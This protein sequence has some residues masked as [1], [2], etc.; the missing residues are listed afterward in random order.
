MKGAQG[1][2]RA[3]GGQGRDVLVGGAGD[4]V[5]VGGAGN[6]RL[7]GRDADRFRD[8]LSCGPGGKDRAFADPGDVVR[9]SCEIVVQNDAPTDVTL[10][11]SSV[12]ENEPVGTEVGT[13]SASDPDPGDSPAFALVAGSGAEGNGAFQIS[14]NTLETAAILDFEAQSTY[15]IRV[16]ATDESGASFEKVLTVAVTNEPE[17]AGNLAPTN[18]TLSNTNVAENQPVNTIVGTLAA[19]DPNAGNTHTFTLVAGTGSADNGS[20]N[21]TAGGVLR[22]SA[23]FDFETD[24]S[25]SIRVRATDQGALFFEKQFTITVTDVAEGGN[26]APTDITLSSNTVAENE[27]VNTTV[28]TLAAVDTVGDTHTFSLV[29]GAGDGDNASFNISGTTLR[30]SAVFNFEADSSYS[31]R[32]RATD[33]GALSLREAVRHHH[34]QRQ[35][36]ADQ[37]HPVQQHRRG[38]RAGEHHRRQPDRDRPGC[39]EHPHLHP[40][41]GYR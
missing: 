2:D 34:H 27:P 7:N 33:Q 16:R 3:T 22:T 25:Y 40:S 20:F 39:W 38:E 32:V 13:L 10:S 29:A 21:I 18:I 4:D 24:S 26:T 5:L 36:G 9:D 12:E 1:E 23:I 41:R 15:S 17:G 28:G 8:V 6:D 19:I 11:P 37:H 30:T 14:G 35:R 31:I